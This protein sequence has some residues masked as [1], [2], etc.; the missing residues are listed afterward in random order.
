MRMKEDHMRNGQLKPGYNPQIS[1]NRQFILNYTIHQCAGDTSTYPLH[2]DDF[3]SLYGSSIP[4][5]ADTL[6]YLS[7]MQGTEARRTICMPSDMV[8]KPS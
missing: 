2:M 6:T 5:T 1:T 7:V 4:F 8:L 3:H